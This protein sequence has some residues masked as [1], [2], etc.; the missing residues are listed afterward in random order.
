MSMKIGN[1]YNLASF[2]R[3]CD[4]ASL[5]GFTD[6]YAGTV[7]AR[8]LTAV[9][10]TIFEKKYPNL[11]FISSGVEANNS[12]GYADRVQSLRLQAL[13]GFTTAGDASGNKGK[14]SLAGEDSFLKVVERE[15][16][17]VWTDTEVRKNEL[18]NINLPQRYIQTFNMQYMRE[19]DQIGL[20][21]VSDGPDTG[22]LNTSEF[23]S[24]SAGD[25]VENLTAQ[26]MYDEIATLIQDQRNGVNNTP[27]YSADTV[28]MPTRVMNRYQATIL[29]SAAGSSTVLKALQDNYPDVTFVSSFR[30]DTTANGGSLA[31][32]ATVAYSTNRESMVMRI[33][34]ALTVGEIVKTNSF[35][36]RVDSKYR[37]A[38]L[39]ILE[40]TAGR[41]LTGL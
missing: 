12:G 33:P 8:N 11:A 28:M 37:I 30:G 25:V 15:A 16:H 5:P 38:G 34:Q 23:T 6:S 2:E 17:A 39:D 22:L 32:S 3:F 20:V 7:L 14:I 24:G 26:E 13:G 9:D 36:F 35:D 27:E 4:S 19:V 29:N 21:G 10:P 31:T 1:V 41:I 18:Q 40:T